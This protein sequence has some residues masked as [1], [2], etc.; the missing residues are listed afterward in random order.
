MSF[1]SR[2][3]RAEDWREIK[4]F[5]ASEFRHPD[6]MGY[7]FVKWLDKLRDVAAVPITLTSSYRD[8]EYNREVGGA[9]D[10]AHTDVPCNAVDIGE[11]PRPGD[12]NW[13]YTRYQIVKTAIA[14]GC[15]RIGTYANGSL[16]L[17]RTE[18]ERPAPV[19]WRV[20]GAVKK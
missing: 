8:P 15:Q 19:M 12:P 2:T 7:E 5:R 10:S 13:N 14:M 17:D 20:V 3:M 11:R 1:S 6:K 16:H 4:N 9:P 18:D